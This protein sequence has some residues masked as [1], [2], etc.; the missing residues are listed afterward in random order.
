MNHA[1]YR[2]V[3]VIG[4]Y[5]LIR[6]FAEEQKNSY[7]QGDDDDDSLSEDSASVEE[8]EEELK[9]PEYKS[10]STTSAK[11]VNL[12]LKK[13]T[14]SPNSGSLSSSNLKPPM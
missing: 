3:P 4:N 1:R 7:D 14:P 10:N 8:V 2:H 13:E 12:D 11:I 9:Q 6:P 5:I